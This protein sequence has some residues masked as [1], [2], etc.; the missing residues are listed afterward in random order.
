[1]PGI[2]QY[3]HV[4]ADESCV[5]LPLRG[6]C[7]KLALAG[8]RR[9]RRRFARRANPNAPK[10]E[11]SSRYVGGHSCLKIRRRKR[12]TNRL[13]LLTREQVKQQKNKAGCQ[14]D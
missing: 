12:E 6:V 5:K 3:A 13:I 10:R 14:S 11:F 4:S 7:G 1:V 8:R 9:S 2:F